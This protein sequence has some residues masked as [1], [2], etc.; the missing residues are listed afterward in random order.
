M[1]HEIVATLV[2]ARHDDLLEQAHRH[3][4]AAARR[5][6]RGRHR[7][8]LRPAGLAAT[9][10]TRTLAAGRAVVATAGGVVAAMAATGASDPSLPRLNGYPLT[11]QAPE[12]TGEAALDG[13]TG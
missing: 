1:H 7:R 5:R 12:P 8:P 6:V 13:L 9:A 10:A 11:R 2:R 4:L 3:R